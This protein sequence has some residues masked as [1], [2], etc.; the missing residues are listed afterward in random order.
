MSA[1][2][3][4]RP[5]SKALA[6]NGVRHGSMARAPATAARATT[7]KPPDSR[8]TSL[9]SGKRQAGMAPRHPAQKGDARQQPTGV[10]RRASPSGR[11]EKVG[12]GRRA[13]AG[14]H[15]TPTSAAAIVAIRTKAGQRVPRL[16]ASRWLATKPT[17]TKTRNAGI[18]R[19]GWR[20]KY[21]LMTF[22][23]TAIQAASAMKAKASGTA[24]APAAAQ[25]PTRSRQVG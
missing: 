14:A 9:S 23:T 15:S 17:T 19:T 25:P 12:R 21:S 11:P 2:A 8:R 10:R 18:S 5:S 7:I 13:H 3:K 24:P 16:G 6:R 22:A 1:P 4:M 20:R